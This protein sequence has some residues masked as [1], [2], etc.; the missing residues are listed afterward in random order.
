M[1]P[2][3][4]IHRAVEHARR[5]GHGHTYLEPRAGRLLT[6]RRP[7]RWPEV[8]VVVIMVAVAA[9]LLGRMLG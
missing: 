9:M 3:A 7:R 2:A 4:I 5:E 8:V 6:E 1:T